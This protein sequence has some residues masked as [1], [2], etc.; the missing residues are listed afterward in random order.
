FTVYVPGETKTPMRPM[1][2]ARRPSSGT[3]NHGAYSGLVRNRASLDGSERKFHQTR[4][5]PAFTGP[6]IV[7]TT[8]PD[9]SEMV[10]VTLS[11]ATSFTPALS[12]TVLSLDARIQ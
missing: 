2:G 1:P 10:S 11:L 4:L 7:R 12:R 3:L 5:M 6:F 8:A 9:A